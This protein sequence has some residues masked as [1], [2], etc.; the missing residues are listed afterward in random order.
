M[1]SDEDGVGMLKTLRGMNANEERKISKGCR[2][3]L[4]TFQ[5][6]NG[7]SLSQYIDAKVVTKDKARI[8]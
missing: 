8:R 3:D 5:T 4:E 6:E 2:I 7:R 1:S